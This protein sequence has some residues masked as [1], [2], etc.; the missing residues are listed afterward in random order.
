MK[1]T[2][3]NG[4]GND[5]IVVAGFSAV[6]DDVQDLA[7]RMC[8]RHFGVGADGLAFIL[9]SDKAEFRM[10]IFNSDG[11]EPEQCGNA[12]RCIGKYLYDYGLTT[13]DEVSVETGAG[14][15]HLKLTVEN[16]KVS[17]VRVDMGAPKLQGSVV[18]TTIDAEQVVAHPIEVP[19]GSYQFT[20]V[21]MGNPHAVI[22]VDS[23]Q[24]VDL[25]G[26]GAQIETHAYFPRKTNVEFVEVHD[27]HDVTMHVWE[28][29]AGETLACGSGACAVAVAGVLTGK[30][31]HEVLVHLKGGDLH[32]NWSREDEHVYMTG[33][34]VT[35]YEG[36]WM[37]S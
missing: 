5:F 35:V 37:L 25:H 2:K 13:R 14:V 27:P 19:G 18:P 17:L 15:Q 29:G 21:S 1:F 16:G 28:R 9:P 32:I 7:V 36:V 8:D 23:L 20:A 26:T 31:S 30:T 11:S 10:R 34:A 4:L 24:D 22:F 33:P 12:V 3:M 6:P